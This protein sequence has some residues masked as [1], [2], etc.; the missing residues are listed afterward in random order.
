MDDFYI[1]DPD[2]LLAWELL[3]AEISNDGG[4]GDP[5]RVPI[6]VGEGY[7]ARIKR[8]ESVPV[9]ARKSTT[10][11]GRKRPESSLATILV[12]VIVFLAILTRCSG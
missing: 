1:E 12:L 5:N 2:R 9:S 6:G 8:G 10:R 3:K 4:Q 11:R 7:R